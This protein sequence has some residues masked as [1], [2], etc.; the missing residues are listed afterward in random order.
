MHWQ[1]LDRAI[2]PAV[3]QWDFTTNPDITCVWDVDDSETVG[4]NNVGAG[5][6]PAVLFPAGATMTTDA[7]L[8][9]DA[10]HVT[11]IRVTATHPNLDVKLTFSSSVESRT[12]R[13]RLTEL[14]PG[15]WEWR[16]CV[17]TPMYQITGPYMQP[18]PPS[19]GYAVPTTM[20][21][22]ITNNGADLLSDRRHYGLQAS[23]EIRPDWRE[24]WWAENCPHGSTM[25]TDTGLPI[26][27]QPWFDPR[28]RYEDMIEAVEAPHQ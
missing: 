16:G 9:A 18:I 6:D 22:S 11:G 21:A 27:H 12:F 20:R 17:T 14:Q 13:P 1:L 7:C 4:S 5:Y 8:F 2:Q 26:D 24:T 25:L 3:E 19:S 28:Y 23:F 10:E 15:F